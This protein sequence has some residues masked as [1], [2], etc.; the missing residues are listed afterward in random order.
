MARGERARAGRRSLRSSADFVCF[1][2]VFGSLLGDGRR[3]ERAG[4]LPPTTSQGCRRPLRIAGRCS[5]G[6]RFFALRASC[7]RGSL[8][9][10]D[11]LGSWT[12]NRRSCGSGVMELVVGVVWLAHQVPEKIF[13]QAGATASTSVRLGDPWCPSVDLTYPRSTV[14]SSCWF[15]PQ[16]MFFQKILQT[17]DRARHGTFADH[18]TTDSF[19]F[20]S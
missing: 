18:V 19:G 9:R 2:M 6:L 12:G 7:A 3:G 11:W 8:R 20:E 5:H 14:P 10:C 13:I 16:V 4:P 15:R 1:L 17:I